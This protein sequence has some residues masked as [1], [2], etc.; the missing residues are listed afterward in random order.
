MNIFSSKVSAHIN[1]L[2]ST[3]YLLHN[4][5]QA[6]PKVCCYTTKKH[7]KAAVSISAHY[8]NRG[9]IFRRIFGILKQ[10][11]MQYLAC[12]KTIS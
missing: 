5:K 11:F 12:M 4:P 10:L 9:R 2:L 8:I 7:H 1:C 6:H 3:V